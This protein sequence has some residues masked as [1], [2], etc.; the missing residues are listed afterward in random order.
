MI[1][2]CMSSFNLIYRTFEIGLSIVCRRGNTFRLLSVGHTAIK[3]TIQGLKHFFGIIL[4]LL[5]RGLFSDVCH[6]QGT[7]VL[8][9]RDSQLFFPD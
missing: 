1:F 7:T 8:Y 5:F 4:D 6:W 3:V 9:L 2:M